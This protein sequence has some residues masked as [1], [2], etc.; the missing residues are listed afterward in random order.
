MENKEE[1]NFREL[2]GDDI[3]HNEQMIEAFSCALQKDKISLSQGRLY[4]TRSVIAFHAQIFGVTTKFV[5]PFSTIKNV[6]RRNTAY[7]IPNAI[8]IET[9]DQTYFFTSFIFRDQAYLV[10]SDTLGESEYTQE[11]DIDA[12]SQDSDSADSQSAEAQVDDKDERDLELKRRLAEPEGILH[13]EEGTEKN[14]EK[15]IE[16]IPLAEIPP[17]KRSSS[18]R[19]H[20]KPK[21]K[22]EEIVVPPQSPIEYPPVSGHC[23][24][25]TEGD[26]QHRQTVLFQETLPISVKDF[27]RAFLDNNSDFWNK[28]NQLYGHIDCTCENWKPSDSGCCVTRAMKFVALLNIKLAPKSTRVTQHNLLASFLRTNC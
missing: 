20:K 17:K 11:S 1:E 18:E 23:A 19:R 8:E 2:F 13:M 21:K 9:T 7:V 27:W 6:S 28:V 25:S 3:P 16:E 12:N 15:M 24:H 10:I 5:I 26:D 14:A 22:R 4:I